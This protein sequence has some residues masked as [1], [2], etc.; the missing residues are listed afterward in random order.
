MR[1]AVLALLTASCAPAA[2]A[3]ASSAEASGLADAAPWSPDLGNGRF[4]NPVVFADYSDPDV[5]RVGDDFYMTASS[6]GSFPALP[7]LHSR[8]LVGWTLV[9]HALPR[10]PDPAFDAPQHGNGVW[11]PS[12]RHHDGWYWIFWG[13]PDRGI[14]RVRAR[15]PRG[16][17]EAPVL[18]KAAKGWIDPAPLWDDDG[19]AYLVHAFARSRSGIKHVLHVARMSPDGTRLLD[20]GRLVFGDSVRHPTM[21]GPKLYKRNGWYYVFAPAGGVPTGWQTVLRSRSIYG[22]YEDRIVLAQGSTA[23]NGPHQGGWVR[24]QTGED[25]FLHF[26]DRGAYGR[27]VHLQPVAWKDDWP[28]MG[29]DA[30]G[31]GTGEPVL[32]FRKPDVGREYPPATPQTTDDFGGDRL[33]L[34]WQWNANPRPEWFSLSERAGWLRMP[35]QALPDSGDNLWPVPGLLLQKLPAPEFTATTRLDFS[36]TVEGERAGLM[37]LGLDY[38]YLALRR[39]ADG[40]ELVQARAKDAHRGGRERAVRIPA[41]SG[42]LFLRVVVGDSALARFAFSRDGVRF[43]EVGE[44]FRARE[45]RWVGARVGLFAVRPRGA[46]PGGRADFDFLRFAPA[47]GG[48]ARP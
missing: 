34:Q 33:G 27:I 39:T 30:D 35:S 19:S 43:Q 36:P 37:V 17:W 31:D 44:P 23:V 12:I 41:P 48:R 26:Q 14:Y 8:D 47:T 4:R 46:A 38:A 20:E 29:V 1:A 28:V 9:G 15:D 21:E 22:P 7:I 24:T 42:P 13:D 6:F 11:A 18:V 10:D 2:V 40:V 5:V 25:W 45:G 3:P 16:P 32:E